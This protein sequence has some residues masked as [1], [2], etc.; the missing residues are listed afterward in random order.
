MIYSVKIMRGNIMRYFISIIIFFGL[1]SSY[2]Y[3]TETQCK[4][5]SK[6][7]FSKAGYIACRNRVDLDKYYEFINTEKK[8]IAE[9]MIAD[10]DRCIIMEGNQ[11]VAVQYN[12]VNKVKI[13]FRGSNRSWWVKSDAV[14]S[15]SQ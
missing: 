13:L 4:F 14:Y 9:Q 10:K 2:T 12:D 3:G 5:N 8:E 1:L 15:K 11:R 7:C 6:E